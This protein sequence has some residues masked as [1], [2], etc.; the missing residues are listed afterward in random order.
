M[1]RNVFDLPEIPDV[2]T[3]DALEPEPPPG[4]N[5]FGLADEEDAGKDRR[6]NDIF[7]ALKENPEEHAAI[8]EVARRAR[9]P[10]DQVEAAFPDLKR[11]AEAVEFDAP[12]F[13]REQPDL[14]RLVLEQP[15]AGK[16]ALRDP[17][18]PVLL[19][20]IKA[21]FQA[22]DEGSWRTGPATPWGLGPLKAGARA[23]EIFDEEQAKP[24]T[25]I[26]MIVDPSAD[27]SWWE[28]LV[29]RRE[30]DEPAQPGAAS[31]EEAWRARAGAYWDAAK[32]GPPPAIDQRQGMRSGPLIPRVATE[33]AAGQR[34]P[35]VLDQAFREGEL[36]LK[37]AELGREWARR[38]VV[39]G[40]AWEVEKQIVDLERR[41]A[42]R[43]YGDDLW[44][45]MLGATG[46]FLPQQIDMYAKA[47]PTAA[48]AYVGAK[49]LPWTRPFA[50]KIAKVAGVGAGWLSA[51]NAEFGGAVIDYGDLRTDTGERVD[52]LSRVGWGVVYGGVSASVEVATELGPVL[53][54]LGPLGDVIRRGELKA[55]GAA[56]LKRDPRFRA[57][58]AD[59]A[60]A[61]AKGVAGEASEEGIQSLS[62]DA[63]GYLARVVQAGG[64]QDADVVGSVER[65][66]AATEQGGLGAVLPGGARSAVNLGTR[67]AG[68]QAAVRGGAAL[69]ALIDGAGTPTART[70]PEF[71][72]ELAKAATERYGEKVEAFYI[73]TPEV[74][75]LFQDEATTAAGLLTEE[76][77]H[78][79]RA[80]MGEQGPERLRTALATGEKLEVPLAEFAEKWAPA[81]V[82]E[83]LK[84]HVSAQPWDRTIAQ[85][86]KAAPEREA[87]AKAIADAI[88]KDEAP[89]GPEEVALE[90]LAEDLVAT[91]RMERD[92]V[93]TDLKLWRKFLNTTSIRGEVPL[94]QLVDEF[95][96]RVRD[97]RAMPVQWAPSS[98][99]LTRRYRG[100]SG[101]EKT[102]AFY[103]DRNTG[104]MNRRAFE[105]LPADPARPLVAHVSIEGTKWANKS[106]HGVGNRLYRAAA[107]A[108]RAAAPD[109]AKVGGDFLVRVKDQAELE[110]LLAKAQAAM[111]VQGLALTGAVGQGPAEA[112]AAHVA[113]KEKLEGEGKRA[114][115]GE[116]P[117]G[118]QVEDAAAL[119]LPDA[120]APA[121]EVPPA[122]RAAFAGLS[123]EQA[124][125][126]AFVEPETG[127]LTGEAFFLLEEVDKKPHV[128]S[129]DLNG[130]RKVNEKF[131]QAAGDA[132]L[133][134][135]GQRAAE[136]HGALFDFAHLSGDEYAARS[137]DAAA[138]Q[139]FI[140]D[141]A[142]MCDNVGDA[143][144]TFGY[145]IGATYDEADRLVEAHKQRG[146]EA[147]REDRRRRL[148]DRGGRDRARG[149]GAPASSPP[150]QGFA[151]ARR[152]PG[153][154]AAEVAAAPLA[155]LAL[156]HRALATLA[157]LQAKHGEGAENLPEFWK[158]REELARAEDALEQGEP[159]R[160][161]LVQHNLTAENLLH[162][163]ELGG[164]A[165]PS[166]AISKKGN[167][168]TGFG[169]ITLLGKPD[170]ADPARGVPVFD[171]DVWS[172]RWPE[173][174]WKIVGP[175]MRAF[176]E[177][178][179]RYAEK[180]GV[181]LG[182]LAD[183]LH[184]RGVEGTLERRD[185]RAAL[186][187][188]YL[189]EKGRPI[190]DKVERVPLNRSESAERALRAFRD[191]HR[192]DLAAFYRGDKPTP[193]A[194]LAAA[195]KKAREEYAAKAF[196]DDAETQAD[197]VADMEKRDVG[198]D[199]FLTMR[200]ED[201]ILQ[202]LLHLDET[203]P[204]KRAMED[205]ALKVTDSKKE[206]PAFEA[207]AKE[208]LSPMFG[209]R[210][211]QKHR[212]TASGPQWYGIPYTIE[213]VVREMARARRIQQ[214]EGGGGV[215]SGVGHLLA[216]AARKYR[217]LEAIKK[218]RARIAPLEETESLRE[219]LSDRVGELASALRPYH[220]AG[221]EMFR[222]FDALLSAIGEAFKRGRSLE[223]ELAKDGFEVQR[224]PAEM[225]AQLRDVM[226][227]LRD[228]PTGYFEAKPQRAVPLQEFVAAVV[229]S[230]VD[231]RV[232]EVLKKRGL[233]VIT[234]KKKR[235]A[236]TEQVEAQE[237][238]RRAAIDKAAAKH[239]LLFQGDGGSRRGWMSAVR[240]GARRIF[241][242]FLDKGAD[243]STFLHE[244]GHVFMDILGE[245][246]S[247]PGAT[248]QLRAD[249]A[250]TLAF[251]GAKDGAELADR[252]RQAAA[253]RAAAAG[254][255]L[256]AEERKEI[257]ALVEPFERWA[258]GF[259]RY[260]MEG[261]AP[262]LELAGAFQRFKLWLTSLYRRVE[263]LGVELNPEIRG[264][265][266]RML[267]T[268]EEIA[269]AR[270]RAAPQAMYRTPEEAG[271]GPEEWQAYLAR[272]ERAMS[273][274][275]LAARQRAARERLKATEAWWRAARRA[276]VEEA[277]EEYDG[278][279]A[280]VALR[281]LRTGD[282]GD[283]AALAALTDAARERKAGEER[284]LHPL[285]SE[286]LRRLD[287]IDRA[288]ADLEVERRLGAEARRVIEAGG[289]V[290]KARETARARL[291]RDVDPL[292]GRS[293]LARVGETVLPTWLSAEEYEQE[294]TAWEWTWAALDIWGKDLDTSG[295]RSRSVDV[296]KRSGKEAPEAAQRAVLGYM[297][298]AFEAF[299]ETD[300]ALIRRGYI[301]AQL[302]AAPKGEFMQ[303]LRGQVAEWMKTPE[304]SRRYDDP[305]S[306]RQWGF[307]DRKYGAR[308]GRWKAE[309]E[310]GVNRAAL[311]A[312]VGEP[313]A[314]DEALAA[315]IA[316]LRKERQAVEAEAEKARVAATRARVKLDYA[317]AIAVLDPNEVKTKLRGLTATENGVQPDDLAEMVAG[318]GDG[319]ALLRDMVSLQP[320]REWA[321]ARADERMRADFPDI[322]TEREQLRRAAEE[323]FHGDE[324]LAWLLHEWDVLRR[325]AGVEGGGAAVDEI[326]RAAE[327]LVGRMRLERLD[328]GRF[329]RAERAAAEKAFV[330]AAKQDFAQAYV[331]WQ[332]RILNHLV[333]REL[334]QAREVRDR[335]EEHGKDLRKPNVRGRLWK[336][337]PAFRDGADQIIEALQLGGPFDHEKP[338]APLSAVVEAIEASGTTVMLD[339]EVIGALLSN[340][341][342]APVQRG[343]VG[344]RWQ[345]L[346]VVQAR[347]VNAALANIRA[348]AAAQL[349]VIVGGK[350]VEWSEH[351][352]ALIEEA[353]RN[354][355][356][357]GPP[358][359]SVDAGGLGD[360]LGGV[361]NGLDGELL[362][363][364]SL[365]HDFLGKDL[366]IESEWFRTVIEPL[367][368]A[369]H[370]EADILREA[371]Q[372]IIEAMDAIPEAVKRRQRDRI[373]GDLLFPTHT[374]LLQAPTRRYE[375][376]SL[377]LNMGNESNL[378]RLLEARGITLDEALR[379]VGLLTREELDYVQTIWDAAEKLRPLAFAIEEKLAG[380]PP[381][382]IEPRPI[383]ITLQDGTE[384]ALRG[385]YFPAVYDRR[386]DVKGERQAD[387]V[388]KGIDF[389]DPGFTRPGTAHSHVKGRVAGTK[390]I[391]SL[392]P[393]I[394]QAHLFQVAHDIAFR[395]AV[396]SVGSVFLDRDIQNL[397]RRRLGE[398]KALLFL[399]WVKDVG[400][401][402]AAEAASQAR[403]WGRVNRGLRSNMAVG[404]LGYAADI[405][406]GD[407]TN[408]GVASQEFKDPR[409]LAAGIAEA[410][411]DPAAA[412][413]WALKNSGEL[414]FRADDQLNTWRR[415]RNELTKRRFPGREAL[416]FY[417]DHAFV[418]FEAMDALTATPV[419][420][421][422]YRE[423]MALYANDHDKAVTYAEA[424]VRRILPSHSVVDMSALQRDRGFWGSVMLFFGYLNTVYG[425]RRAIGHELVVALQEEER[426]TGD[427]GRAVA[428][429]GW[430]MLAVV[431]AY[432]ILGEWLTG[433][434]AEP[435]ERYWQWL[436]RKALM[437][438]TVNDL[439][440]GSLAEPAVTKL[441][442]G[443]AR[444]VSARAAPAVAV[445]E[446]VGRSVMGAFE[447]DEDAFVAAL[448][449][450][451]SLGLA[452]GV[453]ARPL[454]AV[455]YLG[456][457]AGGERQ[458]APPYIPEG[459]SGLIYGERDD[460][461]SNPLRATQDVIDRVTE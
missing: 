54:Q 12:R 386:V 151:G 381:E 6:L 324:M 281:F 295:A 24:R 57:I 10:V 140:D 202:D 87:R 217:S 288:I 105:R 332:Q 204:D 318:E 445:A 257:A 96:V 226:R 282:P 158:A 412:R 375:L 169:E 152:D 227:E 320:R 32:G 106:G 446:E 367:Q 45:R 238:A 259:E 460:Q 409:H 264:V 350:R 14:A 358:T 4:R 413:A 7:V 391:I 395:E 454:R 129:I 382:R 143:R 234:W 93:A 230:D 107:Q 237:A 315:Q 393:T 354:L 392:D 274:S 51:F 306:P 425:R 46:Q 147:E 240:R 174:R 394:I 15:E 128:A 353:E 184:E 120:A 172:P 228:L 89:L 373:D 260:L 34:T 55:L 114:K 378:E 73:D 319:A 166:L 205:A 279:P 220:P 265:F 338:L 67:L 337:N 214:A 164:L 268:D 449:V 327:I 124:F 86:A 175:K 157:V 335:L 303:G 308:F 266:D 366:G 352:A 349:T 273:R 64:L 22:I 154:A 441:V 21:A 242:I 195:A 26:P 285:P 203:R 148:D 277:L 48:L 380:V 61:W 60:R 452:F 368:K 110:S 159:A 246:A 44:S 111:P 387:D 109:V 99:V 233:D 181:Y 252:R 180:T 360:I 16:V 52:P 235:T 364:E 384:V 278:L 256:T 286:V 442:G 311:E 94:A 271:M 261:E 144:I 426:T 183:E 431:V 344:E 88:D 293:D 250:A 83:A 116:R 440:F 90:Q 91:G 101:E 396:L 138:L 244:S 100:L 50:G 372:P 283:N 420:I 400:R 186:G 211:I 192:E 301:L 458:T 421:G 135:F 459:L 408:V 74:L 121:A 371:V 401:A 97:A 457:L 258:R 253:I 71:Y 8:A 365:V 66:L 33:L 198:E 351:R 430:R 263:A 415:H 20:A 5:V 417:T 229:P 298:R 447:G 314:G 38:V 177:W 312:K 119:G 62:Q 438:L 63:V 206:K 410:V 163:D 406:A 81:G 330:A 196:P 47:A 348:A 287:D 323:A 272:Q 309:T 215:L 142:E 310:R 329:E 156:R 379:A 333:Y 370:V 404:L 291:R 80:L 418:F 125:N 197:L 451:R 17:G 69:G 236:T 299:P 340:P 98:E 131:G 31:Q 422:A 328:V 162:A 388:R 23:K 3:A 290:S 450:L 160:D 339:E 423:G 376:I 75:R 150:R 43:F 346:T 82:G 292:V 29:G 284:G 194:E 224:I 334:V 210:Y 218:D 377:A 84:P 241:S 130:L 53:G 223:V 117:L 201:A 347:A 95:V 70:A 428:R 36:G 429:F 300:G 341:P 419:F 405:A 13:R 355:K 453:P 187:L 161:L 25:P 443:K 322:E 276:R 35:G 414:R 424:L 248:A 168:L 336:A 1:A 191:A 137:D 239:D 145:G 178:F 155:Q 247:R 58:V 407:L 342:P 118:V 356:D 307:V 171:R 255:D 132:M 416:D 65:G 56:L 385:G 59:V 41:M 280:A 374:D 390:G 39:G 212:D 305:L 232:V 167:A 179:G 19:S 139:A 190:K 267:A 434:G 188:A 402:R 296:I 189:E 411:R 104:L 316:A 436:L 207:W 122:L 49:A 176:R 126:A 345:G 326:R 133:R 173:T 331:F 216:A 231:P 11:A 30:G 397:L 317:A 134:V 362:R 68:R 185:W 302:L 165:V 269:R 444:R 304:G 141:L 427:V 219:G 369:K 113:V 399:D 153:E 102:R 439:P 361:V 245:L 363:I 225:K 123:D 403:T 2:P 461:P 262:S 200:G 37:R 108:L 208:K 209:E 28:K 433:R 254:R 313:P 456:E 432:Q 85:E 78:A 243:P 321:E 115:R 289:D 42:P 146:V 9:A 72:A 199:G 251:V 249:W 389:L 435:D 193:K 357:R 455:R 275:A 112:G 222:S 270:Q 127:L 221:G 103:I 40:D 437:G 325:R 76:T 297:R 92:E 383:T 136:E 294:P 149:R 398:K 182:N 170:L 448:E 77:E 18:V 213:N 343:R 27:F 359:S 79:A